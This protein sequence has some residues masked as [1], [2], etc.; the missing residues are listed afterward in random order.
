M[1]GKETSANQEPA[2]SRSD[3]IWAA[4][5]LGLPLSA[6]VLAFM[7]QPQFQG[8]LAGRYVEHPIEQIEIVVFCC[9]L[10]ALGSKLL[11]LVRQRRALRHDLVPAWDGKQQPPEQA[12]ALLAGM[13]RLPW[14]VR[15]SWAA[16]RCR[17]VLDFL[18][19]R[20]SAAGL[21]DHVRASSD[22]DAVALD[23]SYAFIRFQ[24]W[25]IPILGFLGTV[26]G[27]TEA[28]AGVSPDQLEKDMSSVT[29]GLATA[30]D[31]TGL[32]LMLTMIT[33]FCSFLVE[34]LEQKTLQ[35]VDDYVDEHLFHRF[36]RPGSDQGPFI[37]AMEKL[38]QSQARVWSASLAEMERQAHTVALDQQERLT[39]ALALAI[40]RSLVGHDAMLSKS[41]QTMH[42]Q[43]TDLMRPL[44]SFAGALKPLAERM[45]E[46]G[47]TLV[48]LQAGEEHMIRLQTLLQQNLETLALAGSFEEA[49]HSLSAAVHLLTARSG[50]KQ[51]LRRDSDQ[52]AA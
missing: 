52:A 25:A 29:G 19:R 48:Q 30:F 36:A 38:V 21:D 13:S 12:A 37:E 47:Q 43:M 40:D 7:Q 42:E 27:I 14:S 2:A 9:A 10:A 3:S 18:C 33:M 8:T 46:L 49:V 51:A 28:I 20:G 17:S 15:K 5:V 41:R 24:I 35:L 34:R 16:Q 31:T 23:A 11:G 50:M 26:L 39:E 45:H 22:N 4:L 44:G 32:A 1:R 6:A